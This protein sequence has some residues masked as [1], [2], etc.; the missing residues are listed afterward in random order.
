[1]AES[2]HRDEFEMLKSIYDEQFEIIQISNPA[3]AIFRAFPQLDSPLLLS[4]LTNGKDDKY[5]Y[6]NMYYIIYVLYILYMYICLY[7][8]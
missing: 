4:Y 1:M 2:A 7:K 5:M 3:T 8:I 6:N